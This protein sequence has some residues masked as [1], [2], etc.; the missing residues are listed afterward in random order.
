[1]HGLLA[2]ERAAVVELFEPRA[3]VD[4]SHRK[5]AARGARLESVHVSASTVHRVL[6]AEGLVL[7]GQPA[8]EPALRAPWPEWIEWKP[9]ACLVLRLRALHPGP[10]G[11]GRRPGRGLEPLAD[12]A[13]LGAGDQQPDRGRVPRY[14][15]AFVREVR[16]TQTE[17]A[18]RVR[19]ELAGGVAG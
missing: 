11:R 18:R 15:H 6:A 3:G 8:R 12:H 17:W 5:L 2:A 4:R 13:G 1:M 9:R 19:G 14:L 7:Q 10:P 16:L